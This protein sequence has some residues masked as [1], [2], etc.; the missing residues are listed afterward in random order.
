[1]IRT[2]S[3]SLEGIPPADDIAINY[4]TDTYHVFGSELLWAA[5][6]EIGINKKQ[7]RI[8]AIQSN[9]SSTNTAL[10]S[11]TGT[12]I[13]G[14]TTRAGVTTDPD[15]GTKTCWYLRADSSDTDTAGVG[16]KRSELL[17]SGDSEAGAMLMEKTYIIGLAQRIAD[18]R[19]TTDEQ[20]TWQIHDNT[21]YA[22]SPWLALLYNGNT[23]TIEIRYSTSATPSQGNTTNQTIWSDS[24]WSPN[25]WEQW[26]IET[27]E[28]QTQGVAKVWLNGILI[29]TYQGPLGYQ[30]PSN[31]GSYWKQ[32]VYHWTDAGN[33]WDSSLSMRETWQ[34]G[35]YIAANIQASDM[36]SN[37]NTIT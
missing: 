23:R 30:E 20:V 35:A 26:V 2:D 22:V 6:T 18:W 1:V 37:L 19:T 32:G 24:N 12:L 15:D 13:G 31:R 25:V 27:K 8:V 14:S 3:V 28:S 10:G 21:G 16:N 11:V 5:D 9:G 29:A 34:K 4:I 33:T 17:P 7:P 36:I